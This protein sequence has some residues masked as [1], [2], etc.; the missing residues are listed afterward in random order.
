[1]LT[2][3]RYSQIWFTIKCAFPVWSDY[4]YNYTTVGLLK[5][6]VKLFAKLGAVLVAIGTVQ[7]AY[8]AGVHHLD[9][10]GWKLILR[11]MMAR[12]LF[13]EGGKIRGVAKKF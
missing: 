9:L 1:M 10:A 4:T 7:T 3:L 13:T 11:Q 5:K 2:H 8:R 6:Y 12:L